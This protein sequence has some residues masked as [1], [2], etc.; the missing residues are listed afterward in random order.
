MESVWNN[1]QHIV[2]TGGLS[3]SLLSLCL[4]IYIY[5]PRD[6]GTLIYNDM[7]LLSGRIYSDSLF[8]SP[9]YFSIISEFFIMNM[10]CKN[11]KTLLQG[12]K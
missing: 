2:L 8:K 7:L 11:C 4:P 1:V 12:G 10:F 3:L 9:L 5:M 6:G